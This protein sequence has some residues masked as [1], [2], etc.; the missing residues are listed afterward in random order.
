MWD[1]SEVSRWIVKD[2]DV[3]TT[4]IHN[5]KKKEEI[6]DEFK[7]NVKSSAKR[8][9]RTTTYNNVNELVLQWSNDVTGRLLRTTLEPESLSVCSRS[10]VD[11]I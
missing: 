4:Q 5:I 6:L 1:T 8:P 9:N 7:K 2:A 11:G 10:R 3:G